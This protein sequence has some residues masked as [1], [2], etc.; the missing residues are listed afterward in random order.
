MTILIYIKWKLFFKENNFKNKEQI[1]NF[2]SIKNFVKNKH[3]F[4]KFK[5]CNKTLVCKCLNKEIKNEI[6]K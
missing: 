3:L 4:Y 1:T 5:Y 2:M 6:I